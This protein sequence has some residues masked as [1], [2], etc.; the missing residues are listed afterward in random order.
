MPH[1]KAFPPL[2]SY[3]CVSYIKVILGEKKVNSKQPTPQ[4]KPHPRTYLR[5][6]RSFKSPAIN[7]ANIGRETHSNKKQTLNLPPRG[8]TNNCIFQGYLLNAFII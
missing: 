6:S 2:N 3:K 8:G 4:K 1:V 5:R 7:F